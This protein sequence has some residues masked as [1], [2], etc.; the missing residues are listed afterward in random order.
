[1]S[2]KMRAVSS[3]PSVARHQLERVRVRDGEHVAL[4][5]PAEAVDGRAVELHALLEGGVQ[6]DRRDGHRLELA[7]HVGEP[8]AHEAH[9]SFLDG[10][11]HVVLLV[12]HAISILAPATTYDRSV[13]AARGR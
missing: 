13:D 5:D 11:Q 4:L 9:P 6:L 3:S 12:V 2:Q 7:E 10:A 8:Q 1:M